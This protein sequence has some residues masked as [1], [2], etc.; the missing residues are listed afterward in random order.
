MPSRRL[1]RPAMVVATLIA[2]SVLILVFIGE[3]LKAFVRKDGVNLGK[4][5]ITF[6]L[7]WQTTMSTPS[8]ARN[9]ISAL[10]D[11]SPDCLNTPASLIIDHTQSQEQAMEEG[12]T[13]VSA[14]L[15]QG[16]NTVSFALQ[17]RS[18]MVSVILA[19]I[20]SLVIHPTGVSNTVRDATGLLAI[21]MAKSRPSI[22]S[23][24]VQSA[25]IPTDLHSLAAFE[26]SKKAV[27]FNAHHHSHGESCDCAA[28][29]SS[30]AAFIP[31][32]IAPPLPTHELM[33]RAFVA[34][35]VTVTVTISVCSDS[36]SKPSNTIGSGNQSSSPASGPDN[37]VSAPESSNPT[38][39]GPGSPSPASNSTSSGPKNPVPG[40]ENSNA[41]SPSRPNPPFTNSTN[42]GAGN[43][44][45]DS[46]GAGSGG[47]GNGGAGSGGAAA[48]SA[49]LGAGA[50]GAA[51][52]SG[53][54]ASAASLFS[55]NTSQPTGNAQS[56]NKGSKPSTTSKSTPAE[57]TSPATS[58][59]ISPPIASQASAASTG[60]DNSIFALITPA[61]TNIVY[62]IST[63][64]PIAVMV[65]MGQI[66]L[67]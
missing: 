40:S 34:R 60:I 23:T 36:A 59:S 30:P 57:N 45:A 21:A 17:G 33:A 32:T 64:G 31:I 20:N 43:E 13:T 24:L 52:A 27:A 15:A 58:A 9:E 54:V 41:T 67:L 48:G 39:S 10:T 16:T 3:G 14:I 19:N 51:S 63:I 28:C 1:G 11:C 65:V 18:D 25:S 5:D 8:T 42:S 62:V 12:S 29:I 44:G 26:L 4:R 55:G 56:S 50:G 37:S 47:A 35:A 46:G 22:S 49:G 7:N 38:S 61:V 66:W 2:F 6:G 53:A